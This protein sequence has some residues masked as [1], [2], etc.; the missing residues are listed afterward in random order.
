MPITL[1]KS[2][3]PIIFLLA[4][5]DKIGW[6]IALHRLGMATNQEEGKLR[7]QTC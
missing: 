6:Q 4:M 7:I 5:E 1:G 3:N 2:I